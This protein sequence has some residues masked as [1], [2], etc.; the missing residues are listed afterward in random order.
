MGADT[1]AS[2]RAALLW[3]C[4]HPGERPSAGGELLPAPRAPP[5][6]AGGVRN[7]TRQRTKK[8][9]AGSQP[10]RAAA[11]RRQDLASL[12]A[13]LPGVLEVRQR[14]WQLRSSPCPMPPCSA[15]VTEQRGPVT[16]QPGAAGNPETPGW[17]SNP[18]KNEC[19]GNPDKCCISPGRGS[20]TPPTWPA[21]TIAFVLEEGNPQAGG[22]YGKE[23]SSPP[24]PPDACC[25]GKIPLSAP[26]Q[27]LCWEHL[28]GARQDVPL[29]G[30]P[31]TCGCCTQAPTPPPP[32]TSVNSLNPVCHPRELTP[33][34]PQRCPAVQAET[35]SPGEI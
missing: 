33:L 27:G 13:A 28:W 35:G 29:P 31:S 8:C 16:H 30:K 4:P 7:T 22:T 14:G 19:R 10:R 5:R 21:S 15:A 6:I 25:H 12:P 26:L 17:R 32:E 24:P 20:S 3:G 1:D 9:G 11:G 34:K 18:G 23:S 2:P